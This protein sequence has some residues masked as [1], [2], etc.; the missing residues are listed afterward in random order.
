MASGDGLS[1]LRS[2]NHLQ[3]GEKH[4]K[5]SLLLSVEQREEALRLSEEVEKQRMRGGGAG[6]ERAGQ[7]RGPSPSLP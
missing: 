1:N 4:G 5:A 2:D 3:V 7:D 6:V